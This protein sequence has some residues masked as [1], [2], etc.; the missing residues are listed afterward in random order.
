LAALFSYSSRSLYT[1]PDGLNNFCILEFEYLLKWYHF[2]YNLSFEPNIR[3]HHSN[4]HL[5]TPNCS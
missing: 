5:V 2:L 1:L 3:M 4:I